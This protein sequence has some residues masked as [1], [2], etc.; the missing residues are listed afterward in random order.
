M[1]YRAVVVETRDAEGLPLS[2]AAYLRLSMAVTYL[3]SKGFAVIRLASASGEQVIGT[4]YYYF[5][6]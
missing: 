5:Q 4:K 2:D 3:V 1:M 6:E